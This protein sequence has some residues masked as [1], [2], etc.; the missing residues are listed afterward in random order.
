M[1]RSLYEE[2]LTLPVERKEAILDR[3]PE[4]V[5]SDMGN[6]PWWFMAR[7]EQLT[8]EGD[9]H[10]WL[11]L[12]GRGFG[13][14]RTCSEWLAK[15]VID[16]PLAPDG[17][18]T[19]WAI[20]AETFGDTRDVCVEGPSGI[21]RAL[22]RLG[23]SRDNGKILYNRSSW[24]IVFDSGQ[25]IHMIG[26]DDKDA[27]RGYNLAGIWADEIAKW[28]YPYE[29]WV[30]G[31]APALR[32]GTNPRAVV[33]T[34]PKPNKL[35]I[36][37][38]G[39]TDGSVYLTRGSTFDNAANLSPTALSEFKARYEGTRIGRQELYGEL[40]MDVEGALWTLSM[41]EQHRS[42]GNPQVVRRVVSIDPAVT[43]NEDSDETGIIVCS[44]DG[45]GHG[46]VEADYSMRGTP[47]EWAQK[48]VAVFDEHQCDAIVI[49][50]NQGG[51][52]VANT[53]RT[54]RSNLPIREVR[55]TKGKRLRAEPISAMYEQGRIHHVG[56]FGDLETQMTNWTQDDPNSPDRLDALVHGFTELMSGGGTEAY[57]RG[58]A[59]VCGCG[60]PNT[61]G[62]EK[63]AS[64]GA[65][66]KA[67]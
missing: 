28:R 57:L 7:P 15:E 4:H 20:I 49:E 59:L 36:D 17:T 45:N 27:G 12:A 50:V 1:S 53:L 32:I 31:I 48:V 54:V 18:P 8:P 26:A 30:E 40:L 34:T 43:A 51:D 63:C 39:R 29:T 47:N 46:Y 66:L 41:I 33:A 21:L 25:R 13:K 22:D 37:W 5:V 23:Y 10:I 62:A 58:L 65:A 19:E 38:I 35:L 44:R 67:G 52:M 60:F 2:W 56:V 16:Q 9:W 55:A 11:L 3:L 6:L 42:G 14:T 64:C 24:Q 61:R